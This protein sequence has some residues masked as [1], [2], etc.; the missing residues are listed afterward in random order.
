MKEKRAGNDR[1]QQHSQVDQ[2][3][4][5]GQD[6]RAQADPLTVIIDHLTTIQGK[7]ETNEQ[8]LDTLVDRVEGIE[9]KLDDK[10]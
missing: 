6:R 7:V 9:R 1:R 5:D 10:T 4:R 8:K 3:H 2:E